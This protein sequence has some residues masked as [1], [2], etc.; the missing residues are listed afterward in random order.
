M[1]K[2]LGIAA[3][4]ALGCQHGD[5]A[6]VDPG[7]DDVFGADERADWYEVPAETV[8]RRIARS[9]ALISFHP[10]TELAAAGIGDAV[11]DLGTKWKLCPDE[12]FAAQPSLTGCTG[13]LVG[14][15]LVATAGHCVEHG[16]DGLSVVFDYAYPAAPADLRADLLMDSSGPYRCIEVVDRSF[17]GHGTSDD[18]Y[19][20]LRLDRTVSDREP[21]RLAR[22]EPAIGAALTLFGY[23]W[24]VPQKIAGGAVVQEVH[25]KRFAS[26]T[27]SFAGNSGS[28]VVDASGVVQGIHVTRASEQHRVMDEARGCY[29]IAHCPEDCDGYPKQFRV[30]RIADRVDALQRCGAVRCD[31]DPAGP[32]DAGPEE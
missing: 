15:D 10:D 12:A 3:L 13:F 22:T 31:S 24:G 1:R 19:A 29:R 23:P 6:F 14:P 7:R 32:A 21:L 11:E 27:D 2:V 25:A 9:V 16:C 20:I 17:T 4:A 8:E 18:D 28:P 30:D 5:D 26:T